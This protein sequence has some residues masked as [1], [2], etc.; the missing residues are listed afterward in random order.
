MT[1]VTIVSHAGLADGAPDDRALAQAIRALGGT[2]RIVAWDQPD[3]NWAASPR[4]VIRSTWNYFHQVEEWRS[5]VRRAS[6][7]TRLINSAELLLWNT[8]K[9]YLMELEAAGIAIV[10]TLMVRD[11]DEATSQLDAAGWTDVI[12]KPAIG[13]SAHGARRFLSREGLGDHAASLA[14]TGAVLIQPF[15]PSVENERERS[16]V[17][18]AGRYSHAFTKPAFDPGGGADAKSR[19][20]PHEPTAQEH[21]LATTALAALPAA[22]DYARIDMVPSPDDPR[23]MEVELIEPDLLLR[24]NPAALGTFAAHLLST[25]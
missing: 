25:L 13:A 10:P 2:A 16:L 15:Q 1:D 12:V 22:T 6:T 24:E 17:F 14:Q 9:S 7:Q 11:A 19:F 4:T 20:V 5:W 23:I 8:E 21:T 3:A 18:L